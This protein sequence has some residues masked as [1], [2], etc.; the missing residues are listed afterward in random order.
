MATVNF[1]QWYDDVLPHAPGCASAM[2]LDAIR[3]AAIEFC[4]ETRVWR[5]EHP[6]VTVSANVAEYPF[7]PPTDTVVS[8]ILDAW[9]DGVWLEPL[10]PDELADINGNWLTWTGPRPIYVTQS[11]ERTVRLV[12]EPTVTLADGLT[13]LVAL[14]PAHDATTIEERLYEE[15]REEIA[16]GA[17]ARLLMSPKKPYSD[18]ALGP[19][20]AAEFRSHC[21]IVYNR[22][23][24]GHTRASAFTMRLR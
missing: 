14:K 5:Y 4:K 24:R 3:K 1:S 15:Y 7:T 21:N 19:Q 6:A 2:A 13:M 16:C 9:Y 11:D 18:P 22:A 10:G 12:P 17:L 8:E 23:A 20:K